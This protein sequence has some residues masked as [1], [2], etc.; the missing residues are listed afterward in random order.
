MITFE[1]GNMLI[2]IL[3][4]CQIA[5]SDKNSKNNAVDEKIM[6]KLSAEGND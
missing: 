1:L 2:A 5:K 6:P 4:G 3:D